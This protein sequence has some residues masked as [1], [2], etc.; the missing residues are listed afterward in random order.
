M[1]LQE[2]IIAQ[3]QESNILLF[4]VL[5]ALFVVAYKVLR[6]VINTAMIA[7]LSGVF[8]VALDFVGLGPRVTVNRFMFFMVLGTGLFILYSALATVIRTSS[9]LAGALKTIGGWLAKPFRHPDENGSADKEKE[10]VLE[11]LKDD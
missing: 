1:A 9:S 8:L 10:I 6:A 4:I 2:L 5:I 3:L 11:E 7:V